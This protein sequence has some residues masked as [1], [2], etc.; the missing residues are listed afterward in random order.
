M[1]ALGFRSNRK[2]TRTRVDETTLYVFCFNRCDT[3][4]FVQMA[5]ALSDGLLAFR[6]LKVGGTII[7]DNEANTAAVAE[8]TAALESALGDGLQVLHRQVS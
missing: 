1:D 3:R 7:F 6:L 8:A 2:K 5:D 4:L